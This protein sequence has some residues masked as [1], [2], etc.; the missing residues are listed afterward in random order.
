MF[1]LYLGYVLFRLVRE[2]VIL[3]FVWLVELGVV[4]KWVVFIREVSVVVFW[5]ENDCIF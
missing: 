2:E 3:P 1:L 5:V 4:R